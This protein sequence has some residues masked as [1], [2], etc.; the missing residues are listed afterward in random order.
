MAV[1][2]FGL[3]IERKAHSLLSISVSED[4]QRKPGP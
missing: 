1:D 4:L 2:L 3:G